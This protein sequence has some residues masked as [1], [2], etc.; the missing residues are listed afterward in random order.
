MQRRVSNRPNLPIVAL[1]DPHLGREQAAALH[2]T[3][4]ILRTLGPLT[5]LPVKTSESELL[6]YLEANPARLVLLPWNCYL[7]WTRIEGLFGIS[8]SSGPTCAG[9]FAS[10]VDARELGAIGDTQRLI[11]FDFHATSFSERWRLVRSLLHEEFRAGI[12]PLLHDKAPIY[13]KEWLGSEGPGAALDS[14]LA[15]EAVQQAPWKERIQPIQLLA[16][17]LWNLAYEQGRTLMRGGW[18]TQLHAHRVRAHLE[19][20]MDSELLALRLCYHQQ[21]NTPRSVLREFWPDAQKSEDFRQHLSRNADFVRVHTVPDRDEVEIVATLLK[22]SPARHRPDDLRTIWIEPISSRLIQEIPGKPA[23]EA[24]ARR[25]RTLNTQPGLTPEQAQARIQ[26]LERELAQKERKIAD[27]TDGVA[28]AA[29]D[30][31][32]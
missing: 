24:K 32:S 20:G 6:A 23:S 4:A 14:I 3:W 21:P 9:Y 7:E 2:R 31:A 12:Q 15:L 18:L 22:S 28:P 13:T 5:V 10:A 25:Y 30:K 17:T 29:E 8:R 16:L 27:L 11:L 26:W 1:P 19:I